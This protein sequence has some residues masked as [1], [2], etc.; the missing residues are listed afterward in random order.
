[1]EDIPFGKVVKRFCGEVLRAAIPSLL[2]ILTDK[3][4]QAV[5][6]A[7]NGTAI[8]EQAAPT[9][10]EDAGPGGAGVAAQPA[11]GFL[12]KLAESLEEKIELHGEQ[13]QILLAALHASVPTGKVIAV[14]AP[15]AGAELL[16]LGK[17]ISV[18][19]EQIVIHGEPCNFP[20][21]F[22]NFMLFMPQG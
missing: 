13:A 16:N 7:D 20:I 5:S 2:A 10:Q 8:I 3:Q 14:F 21:L 15:D 17:K 6:P 4:R 19:P 12:W 1:M 18:I 11:S 22:L 9:M